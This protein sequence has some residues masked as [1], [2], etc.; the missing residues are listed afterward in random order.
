M[1]DIVFYLD[2]DGVEADYAAGMVALGYD[3]SPSLGRQLNVSGTHHPLKREMYER[4]R[5]TEFYRTLPI[6]A[7]G[8]DIYNAVADT[9]PVILTAA[10]KFGSTED[11]FH[12]NPHW[13]GAAYHKRHWVEHTLLPACAEAQFWSSR[14][15]EDISIWVD[16]RAPSRIAIPDDHFIC[17]TSARKQ[18]FM[19]RKKAPHQVLI[20]DRI[21]NCDRWVE[22]GG[23]AILH[24]DV[25]FT[26]DT[27]KHLREGRSGSPF[28]DGALRPCLY[29]PYDRISEGARA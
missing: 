2:L 19:H 7:G 18:E 9:D 21:A 14:A 17:T 8:V 28:G 20:D 29:L 15:D 4:I 12:V 16:W 5:G 24:D 13:L 25:Q 26:L 22:A 6:M 10:P 3:V 1:T 27:I 23:I 11:D